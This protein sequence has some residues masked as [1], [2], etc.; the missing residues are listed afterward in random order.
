MLPLPESQCH[1]AFE[2]EHGVPVWP[3][4]GNYRYPALIR[5]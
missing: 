4:D 2:C 3:F 5:G 1:I